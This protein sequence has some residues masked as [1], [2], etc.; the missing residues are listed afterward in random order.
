MATSRLCSIPD[1]GKRHLALGYC[2]GHYDQVRKGNEPTPL[3]GTPAR[4]HRAVPITEMLSFI[5]MA[6]RTETD[7]CIDWPWM[8]D[9]LRHG[10]FI[11]RVRKG[12]ARWVQAHR[13]ACRAIHGPPPFPDAHAAHGCGRACCVNPKHL[14]WA[15]AA[16]N[17][18]D[19]KV[20]GT[21]ARGVDAPTAK[22]TDAQAAKMRL[23]AKHWP[24]RVLAKRYGVTLN[25]VNKVLAGKSWGHVGGAKPRR[26]FRARIPHDEAP[27]AFGGVRRRGGTTVRPGRFV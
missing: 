2:R 10:K 19:K 8:A 15:T 23:D 11:A 1:C 18:A 4:Q 21:Q 22:L 17:M 27:Q 6:V 13:I 14:R 26:A 3:T 5:E 9:R 7:L 16:Q 20:H 12:K 25:T 24:Q